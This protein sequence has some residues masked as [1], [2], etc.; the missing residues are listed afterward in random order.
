V[1][2]DQPMSD[3]LEDLPATARRIVETTRRLLI[4][5]G[6]GYLSIENIA[7]ECGLNKA[8]IRY[9]F[10]NKAGLMELVVDSWVHDNFRYMEPL[11]SLTTEPVLRDRESLHAFMHAK[12]E[13]VK[14]TEMYLAFFELLPAML[15][16][17]RNSGRIEELYEWAAQM[18][19][20]LFASSLPGLDAAQQRGFAQLLFAV[21]DG[22]GAQGVISSERFPPDAA[23]DLLAEILAAWAGVR[24]GG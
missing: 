17:R 14:D 11:A 15:R 22:L 9:Y 1:P 5:R 10:R 23:M 3:P 24:A 7:T 12:L 20:R 4:E 18:Y 21:V 8:A 6:Y 16:D 19:A 13:M 2:V